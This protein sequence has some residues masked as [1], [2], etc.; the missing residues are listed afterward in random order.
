MEPVG[1]RV[2][3]GGFWM[4][5]VGD[6]W[7][8]P[9]GALCT[10]AGLT[11]AGMPEPGPTESGAD[12]IEPVGLR[13]AERVCEERPGTLTG[14]GGSV[15]R[16]GESSA[17]SAI[18]FCSR[19]IS[20]VGLRVRVDWASSFANCLSRGGGGVSR[21]PSA[22]ADAEEALGSSVGALLLGTNMGALSAGTSAGP[23]SEGSRTGALCDGSRAGLL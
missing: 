10:G 4:L 6:F 18:V 20:A 19:L 5:P 11:L 1:R 16:V 17:G 8:V 13:T 22:R 21:I 14:T 7:T 2:G 3:A 9:V 12:A 23:L 15:G